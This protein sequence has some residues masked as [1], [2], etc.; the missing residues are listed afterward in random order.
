MLFTQSNVYY[1]G[2]YKIDV[3][4]F[5]CPLPC[6]PFIAKVW[7]ICKVR[8]SDI[9]VS[10]VGCQS[11]FNSKYDL[12]VADSLSFYRLPQMAKMKP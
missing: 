9:R 4:Y 2:D 1:A 3:S 6:S 11:S 5:D 12:C 7:D 8:M 10:Y